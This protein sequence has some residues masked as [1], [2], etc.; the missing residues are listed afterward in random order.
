MAQAM[1]GSG[2]LQVTSIERRAEG[3]KHFGSSALLQ[4]G[5]ALKRLQGEP[6]EGGPVPGQAL[7]L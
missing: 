1:D 4:L 2:R 7:A 5:L 6:A 3:L